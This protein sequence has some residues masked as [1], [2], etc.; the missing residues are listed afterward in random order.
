MDP[1]GKHVN[2]AHRGLTGPARHVD[3]VPRGFSGPARHVDPAP[4]GL[5]DLSRHSGS[6]ATE[7]R[8]GDNDGVTTITITRRL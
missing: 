7:Y 6:M 5:V 4:R 1:P 8:D 3:P 2:L